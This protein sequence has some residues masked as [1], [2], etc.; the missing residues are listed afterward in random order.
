MKKHI[1]PPQSPSLAATIDQLCRPRFRRATGDIATADDLCQKLWLKM[2]GHKARHGEPDDERRLAGVASASLIKDWWRR[3]R[4]LAGK[5]VPAN[6]VYPPDETTLSAEES[7]S[8]AELRAEVRAELT[9]TVK[10]ARHLDILLAGDEDAASIAERLGTTPTAV[11][12][13]RHKLIK[14]LRQNPRLREL[15][16]ESLAA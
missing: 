15:W 3:E 11:R 10:N 9:R 2:A 8:S 5:F 1:D 16:L 6:D 13:Y 14:R 4:V 7:L 12:T